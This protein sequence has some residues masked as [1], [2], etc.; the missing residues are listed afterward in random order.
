[1]DTF[2]SSPTTHTHAPNP[3]HVT[4]IELNNQVKARAANSD[5]PTSSIL[6]TALRNFPLSATNELPRTDMILQT[7]RRQRA[8]PKAQS[9]DRLPEAFRKTDRGEDFVLF[10]NSGMIIFTTKTNLSVMKSAKHWFADGT[11]KVCP[12]SGEFRL[13]S[14]SV[15]LG[16]P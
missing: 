13:I 8:T 3:E 15:S 9:G 14:I 12:E 7:I 2:L 5:E 16:L 6:Y 10:E 4:V 11:F 1:M